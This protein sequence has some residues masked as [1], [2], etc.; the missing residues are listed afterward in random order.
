MIKHICLFSSQLLHIP[1]LQ[2]FRISEEAMHLVG[3][4]QDMSLAFVATEFNE[5]FSGRQPCQD[6]KVFRRFRN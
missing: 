4:W 3:I 5:M 2:Q 1:A 6:V